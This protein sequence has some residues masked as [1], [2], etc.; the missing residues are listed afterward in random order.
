MSVQAVMLTDVERVVLRR[1]VIEPHRDGID[2]IGARHVLAE[3]LQISGGGDDA[4]VLKTDYSVGRF[5]NCENITVC[6]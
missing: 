1:L 6:L 5:V 2:L 4:F 3:E